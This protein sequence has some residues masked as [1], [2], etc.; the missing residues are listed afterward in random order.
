MGLFSSLNLSNNFTNG[1]G[2]F[3]N[4]SQA[5]NLFSNTQNSIFSSANSLF[6]NNKT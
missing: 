1:T 6:S 5:P 3:G 4:I 2:L